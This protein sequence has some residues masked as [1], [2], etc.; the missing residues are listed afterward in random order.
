MIFRFYRILTHIGGP[1]ITAYLNKRKMEGKEDPVRFGERL[2]NPGVVRPVGPLVWL[3]GA[4]VGEAASLLPLINELNKWKALNILIT[5]GSVTSAALMA[6][7]LPENVIHQYI[8]VDRLPY[9]KNF[10]DHWKPDLAVWCES[11]FWPNLI[12]ETNE[13]GTPLIL[14][15]GRVSEKSFRGWQ[16]ARSLIAKVLSRFD[17][18]IGQTKEDASRLGRLGAKKTKCHG[19]LKFA[20]PPLPVDDE[21][22][23]QMKQAIGDRPVWFAASTHAGEELLVGRVHEKLK[24][25]YPNLLT[26][27]APRHPDRGKVIATDLLD[28]GFK[29]SVRSHNQ[30]IRENTDIYLADTM[31]ELGLFF[32]AANL[33]FM[34]KSL[35][36]RGGQNPLEPAL[37][38]CSI[39]HGPHMDNFVEISQDFS[40][41]KAAITVTD[42][43]ELIEVIARLLKDEVERETLGEAAQSL[44]EERAGVLEAIMEDLTPYLHRLTL[45]DVNHEGS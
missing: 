42:E 25:Q 41:K 40:E 4:S 5:T 12:C 38:G 44:A 16:K 37:L 6:K 30:P 9:V 29:I 39:V 26:I 32:R 27:I 3:H 7:R 22:L 1:V 8:P 18:C 33:V 35:I 34:G 11:E 45:K 31:G 20:A 14:V 15:N 2:G 24:A 19:N 36:A 17:L 10:L 23:L 13:R 28:I 21:E 43:D